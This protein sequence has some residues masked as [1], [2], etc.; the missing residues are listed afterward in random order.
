M[1]HVPLRPQPLVF[2]QR[3]DRPAAGG[4]PAPPPP[5]PRVF[6]NPPAGP[7]AGVDPGAARPPTNSPA[8][9]TPFIGRQ[10]AVDGLVWLLTAEGVRLLTLTGPGGVGKTRLA[11]QAAQQ[12]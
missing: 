5:P 12:V 6:P 3:P 8:P 1:S 4:A 2:P 9:L 10:A 7:G 11:L